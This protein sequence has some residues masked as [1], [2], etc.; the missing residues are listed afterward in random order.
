MGKLVAFWSPYAG[1]AKVTSSLCAIVGAFGM[2]YPEYT[3]AIS[4]IPTGFLGLEC[5]LDHQLANRQGE[6]KVRE[7]YEKNGMAA[8]ALNY[9]QAVLT[10]EKIRRCAVPLMMKSLFLYPHGSKEIMEDDMLSQL[11][12]E[13]LKT[14]YDV[15]FLDLGNGHDDS[16]DVWI[17]MADYVVVILPQSP[18]YWKQ[19]YSYELDFWKRKQ[20]CILIGGYLEESKYSIG[21]Y[22][23]KREFRAC[24]HLAGAIP[25]NA[26]FADAMSEGKTLDFFLR[27]QLAVKKEE[28][29]GF[30]VQTKKAAD[31]IKKNIFVP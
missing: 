15:V 14:E 5:R 1:L 3:V 4:Q 30:V 11:V 21:Y 29:Y 31:Y 28:N 12:G 16:T 24:G 10:S 17:D 23:K 6:K 9:M 19:F 20:F 7:W 27:N 13:Y 22:R 25:M 18:L 2:Q 26:G 8:L